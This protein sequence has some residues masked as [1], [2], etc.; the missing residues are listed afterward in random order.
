MFALAQGDRP[1]KWYGALYLLL[2][3]SNLSHKSD[4]PSY[5]LSEIE[6]RTLVTRQISTDWAN[7]SKRGKLYELT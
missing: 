1:P 2:P 6:P 7:R 4:Y 5:T 3:P